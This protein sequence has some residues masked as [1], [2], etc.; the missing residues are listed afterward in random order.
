M[1]VT[2]PPLQK[3]NGPL[4]LIVGLGGSEL[5]VTV[6]ELVVMLHPCGEVTMALYVPPVLT[7]I[8]DEVLLLFQRIEFPEAVVTVNCTL[9]PWQN[10][11][12]PPAPMLAVGFALTVTV[13]V[14][15]E[16]EQ[17]EEFVTVTE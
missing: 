12:L 2:L 6:I 3:V 8:D 9:S 14:V 11:V 7:L 13:T 16:E 17:P 4:A 10:V 15:G 1:R 5:T